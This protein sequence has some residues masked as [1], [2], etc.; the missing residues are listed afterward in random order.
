MEFSRDNHLSCWVRFGNGVLSGVLSI[1]CGLFAYSLVV[2]TTGTFSAVAGGIALAVVMLPITVRTVEEGLRAL[3]IELR[4]GAIALGATTSQT[5]FG[6]V[7]P[8]AAPGIITGVILA[9]ARAI[10]ETAPLLFTALFSQYGINGLWN[11]IASLS[12]LIYNFALSP[13]PNY[14]A[15]AWTAALV[16]VGL[17]L[18][19]SVGARSLTRNLTQ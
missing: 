12:V 9:M 7:L 5:I 16:L 4:E 2:L 11:P 13:Y 18:V 19:V 1:L 3:T 6:V 17:I 8:T 15:L 10:G 14:Q